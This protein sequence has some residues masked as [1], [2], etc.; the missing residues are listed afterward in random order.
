MQLYNRFLLKKV[1]LL[2][3]L[4]VIANLNAQPNYYS[5]SFQEDVGNPG[6]FNNEAD[7][8]T[9]GWL[10]LIGGS[11]FGN[12]WS[13]INPIPVGFDFDFFGVLVTSA[14]ISGNGV[15]SFNSTATAIP[16]STNTNLPAI[17][18]N[19]PDYSI[20][21]FWDAF[22]GDGYTGSNDSVEYKIF[23]TA[24]NRQIWFKYSHYEYGD[25]GNGGP[26]TT[27]YWAI[28]LEES[29]HKVYVVDMNFGGSNLTATIGVQENSTRAIQYG[30][31]N[32]N[33]NNPGNSSQFQSNNDYYMFTPVILDSNNIE[34]LTSSAIPNPYSAGVQN[35]DVYVK[36]V[37]ANPI[38]TVDINW[39]V[40][41]VLQTPYNYSG[42]L[43]FD[44]SISITIGT[45]NFGSGASNIEIWTSM[46]NGVTDGDMTNDSIQMDVCSGLSGTYT[47]GAGGDYPNIDSA[48]NDLNNCGVLGPVVFN[49]MPGNYFETILLEEIA[50]VSATNTIMFNG[51]NPNSTSILYNGLGSSNS[52]ITL[53]GS[54]HVTIKN[55][56]IQN[57]SISSTGRGVFLTNA[58]DYNTIDSCR[59]VV[60]S[61]S[62]SPSYIP[63][64]ASS[65]SINTINGTGNN[66]NYTTIS[67]CEIEGGY[68]GVMLAGSNSNTPDNSSNRIINCNITDVYNYGMYLRYQDRPVISNNTVGTP[69]NT[70][71]GYSCR[72]S[73]KEPEITKNIFLGAKTTGLYLFECNTIGQSFTQNGLVA[74]N[75]IRTSGAAEGLYLNGSDYISIFHNTIVSENESALWVTSNSNFLDIRNN[76]FVTEISTSAIPAVDFDS[77]PNGT[78]VIDYNIY[79]GQWIAHMGSSSYSS[80]ASWVAAEATLNINSIEGDPGFIT[81]NN[82]HVA[83]SIAESEGTP[84]SLV[85][86][87]IDGDI[88]STTVPDIGADEYTFCP[89]PSSISSANITPNSSLINWV[90]GGSETTWNIEYGNGGFTLGSGSQIIGQT[91]TNY[92]LSSLLANTTYD[93]YI[94]ADCGGSQSYWTGPFTFTSACQ[95]FLAPFT[96]T[97]TSNSTPS[98]WSQSSTAGGPWEFTSFS[99]SFT[100]CG[101]M[102]DH[103]TSLTSNYAYVDQSGTDAG[104]ILTMNTV[105][106]TALTTPFLQFYYSQC[107]L[108]IS[109]MNS[110]YVE[111]WDG[112]VWQ[113][114]GLIQDA[115]DGDWKFYEFNLSNYVFNSNLVKVRFRAESGGD[116]NDDNGDILIDDVSILE[117]PICAMPSALN[118][119]IINSSTIE[120]S[121]TPQ[122]SESEWTIEYGTAGF[123]LGSGTQVSNV[124]TNIDTVSGLLVN[125]AY[126]YYVRA[127]CG[128]GNS[129]LWAG[130]FQYIFE[131]CTPA[132]TSFTGATIIEVVMG[133]INNSTGTEPGYYADYTYLSTDVNQGGT[134]EFYLEFFSSSAAGANIWIDWNNDLFFSSSEIVFTGASASTFPFDITASFAVPSTASLGLHTMRI[135]GSQQFSGPGNPCYSGSNATFEDYTINVVPACTININDSHTACGSYIWRDGIT[136]TSSNSTATDSIFSVNGG[137]CDTIYTLDLTINNSVSSVDIQEA[138]D[139]FT[140]INGVTYFT[141]NFTAVETLTTSTG[142]DSIITLNL[143]INSSMQNTDVITACETYTWID[144]VTYTTSNNSAVYTA[145]LSNGCD[146]I[147]ILDLTITDPDES[148]TQT[149]GIYLIS[150]QPGASYRWLDCDN[151]YTV[152]GGAINQLFIA[153]SNGDYAVEVTYLGCI[154]T[155]ACISVSNVGLDDVNTTFANVYPNPVNDILTITFNDLDNAQFELMDLQGK[156]V[157]SSTTV[158][159]GQKVDVSGLESGIYFVRLTSDD[160]RM[161]KRIVKN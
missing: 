101:N 1:F 136:Y 154:D 126:E 117:S 150:N 86:E 90:A 57:T 77:N 133:S 28:V 92:T 81:A 135:G 129:S 113:E 35:V 80:L 64:I 106:V 67:N 132:P 115:T 145:T 83:G 94:Q 79:N 44:D 148:I 128:S 73:G 102:Y 139:E 127:E 72:V 32:I 36:N 54:D 111:A 45:Y 103:T 74:N 124:M 158:I 15:L 65:N 104:V 40:N 29:T 55:V 56:T 71:S 159:N 26:L 58:A 17:G 12:S 130:P 50:G 52:V 66:A 137:T 161:I 78:T 16:S 70:N 85:S 69:R 7:N 100:P 11:Q 37:G 149:D 42:N 146:S 95:P 20:L 4:M 125:T 60:N 151:G 84:I 21:G 89:S 131:Y 97:F 87:D 140:W 98:C 51:G 156:I 14:K 24:P 152:I 99:G 143:V 116:V 13:S 2:G 53:N 138:C 96:E 30:S 110:L 157:I 109:T 3:F 153:S 108:N 141:N 49:I 114:L 91:S 107:D 47:I 134:Q 62:S 48:A 144:G 9:S 155:S 75:M 121:W 33:M 105:D 68:Y 10:T 88:R 39:K 43:D 118:A 142:C 82:L 41:G 22:T 112:A 61:I 38:T 93:I 23:G 123:P 18:S 6:V 25:N 5:L 8:L 122:G 27:A 147:V 76:I 119:S 46:P 63:I 59:I 120:L 31:N 19:I 34:V 160:N